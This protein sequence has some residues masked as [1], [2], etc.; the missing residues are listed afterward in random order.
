MGEIAITIIKWTF[1]GAFIIAVAIAIASL[2]SIIGNYLII[3]FNTSVL[4][5]IFALIQIWLPFNL[6]ILLIWVAVA[7]TAYLTYRLAIIANVLL[8]SFIGKY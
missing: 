5:D 6:N 1:R 3:G 2:L 4:A 8:N 7:S